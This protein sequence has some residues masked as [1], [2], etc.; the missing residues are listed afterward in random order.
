MYQQEHFHPATYIVILQGTHKGTFQI[1]YVNMTVERYLQLRKD[2]IWQELHLFLKCLWK[3]RYQ[4]KYQEKW[5]KLTVAR[6]AYYKSAMVSNMNN[7]LQLLEHLDQTGTF[8]ILEK[9]L[10]KKKGL[11]IQIGHHFDTKPPE[12]L[13][14]V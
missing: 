13:G 6:S 3:Y 11:E 9:K 5:I 8:C 7:T 12:F 2:S 4:G 14:Y 10:T 1:L